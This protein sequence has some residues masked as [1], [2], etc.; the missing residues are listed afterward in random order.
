MPKNAKDNLKEA[1]DELCCCQ[2]HLNV[3]YM[4]SEDTQNRTEIHAALKAVGSAVNSAQHTLLH[5]KH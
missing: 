4:Q 3:A 1:V 2:N 5:Y